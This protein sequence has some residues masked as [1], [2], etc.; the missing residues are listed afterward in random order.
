EEDEMQALRRQPEDEDEMQALRRQPEEEDKTQALRRQPEE[1]D[2]MQALRR[3]P[4]DE[5]EMQALRRQPE[6]EDEMQALRRQPEEEDE[7]QALR[8]QTEVEEEP[9][10]MLRRA[11]SRL[12][13]DPETA[14]FPEEM[15]D[16]GEPSPLSALRREDAVAVG[17]PPAFDPVAM[18]GAPPIDPPHGDRFTRPAVH[19]DQLDVLIHEPAAAPG[20]GHNA[21]R[22]R[23]IRARYLRR[24]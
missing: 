2:E 6:E 4:E 21:D 12:G 3:Q 14:P 11:G 24:L 7:M 5:D 10:H 23:A 17:M 16:E 18:P 13:L 8:R 22:S 20:A 19:I 1:E 9:V 15:R